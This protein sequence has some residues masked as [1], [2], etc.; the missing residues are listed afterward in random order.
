MIFGHENSIYTCYLINKRIKKVAR[1]LEFV[2]YMVHI[3]DDILTVIRGLSIIS[4]KSNS[5]NKVIMDR[6][7]NNFWTHCIPILLYQKV[8]EEIFR[9]ISRDILSRI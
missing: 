3:T 4:F 5:K 1:R 8:L 2:A 9:E 6:W 7:A